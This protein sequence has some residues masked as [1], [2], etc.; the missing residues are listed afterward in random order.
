MGTVYVD[1]RILES[2]GRPLKTYGLLESKRALDARKTGQILPLKGVNVPGD[3]RQ[4]PALFP[5][6]EVG[7]FYLSTVSHS[8]WFIVKGSAGNVENPL[9]DGQENDAYSYFIH[10]HPMRKEVHFIPSIE[11]LETCSRQPEVVVSGSGVARY[12]K[13]PAA[14]R[15]Q[16]GFLVEGAGTSRPYRINYT[17]WLNN[18]ACYPFSRLVERT[19]CRV[20]V[21]GKIFEDGHSRVIDYLPWHLL[22]PLVDKWGIRCLFD[23]GIKWRP[24][25]IVSTTAAAASGQS[26]EKSA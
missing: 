19:G 25:E 23:K 21:F 10:N 2:Y 7:L 15:K 3:I 9:K 5:R 12:Y 18:P 20:Q 26:R 14:G 6:Y 17:R 24:R 13:V 16:P 1:R 4:L 11:D 8:Q 22:E